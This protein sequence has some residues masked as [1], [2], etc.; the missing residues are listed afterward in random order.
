MYVFV[1]LR[2]LQGTV[3][4]SEAFFNQRAPKVV[5]FSSRGPNTLAA[6]LLKVTHLFFK[7]FIGFLKEK[8]SKITFESF[9][10]KEHLMRKMIK[11]VL[12]K[13]KNKFI[14]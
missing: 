11:K 6:N 7:I 2:S 14:L 10:T 9:I 12:L 3:L 1:F 8:F 5:S 13:G 4:K